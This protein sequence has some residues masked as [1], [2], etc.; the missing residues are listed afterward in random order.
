MVT[1]DHYHTYLSL[2]KVAYGVVAQSARK[3]TGAVIAQCGS[4]FE[5]ALP[6]GMA[7]EVA[8]DQAPVK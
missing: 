1:D 2:G 5:M 3:L 7:L 8:H 4:G 6:D